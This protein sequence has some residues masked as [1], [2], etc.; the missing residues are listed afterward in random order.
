MARPRL[1]P[2]SNE[3]RERY[4]QRLREARDAKG[5]TLQQVG[6]HIGVAFGT[7][8]NIEK[9]RLRVTPERLA[10][11]AELYGVDVAAITGERAA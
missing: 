10:Q 2:V 11:L 3:T 7:V 5:L 4:G 9:G 6:E 8:Q 1:H